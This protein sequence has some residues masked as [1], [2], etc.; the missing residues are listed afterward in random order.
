MCDEPPT[1]DCYY[2]EENHEIG[3]LRTLDTLSNVGWAPTWWSWKNGENDVT[4][5]WSIFRRPSSSVSGLGLLPEAWSSTSQVLALNFA[6]SVS[7]WVHHHWTD[8]V[9]PLEFQMEAQDDYVLKGSCLSSPHFCGFQVNFERESRRWSI[10]VPVISCF[11]FGGILGENPKTINWRL[12]FIPEKLYI[13]I[14]SF[15]KTPYSGALPVYRY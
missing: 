14:L 11:H 8:D 2:S 1:N 7:K 12:Y 5:G 9:K 15:K 3:Q 10:T 13:P 4:G 6:V